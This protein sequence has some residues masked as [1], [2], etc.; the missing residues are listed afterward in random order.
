[1]GRGLWARCLLALAAVAGSVTLIGTIANS[2][3]AA[4]SNRYCTVRFVTVKFVPSTV[5]EGGSTQ[6]QETIRNCTVRVQKVTDTVFGREPCAVIDPAAHSITVPP[7]GRVNE[8]YGFTALSCT[9]TATVTTR[10]TSSIGK[11]FG[12]RTATFTIIA[13]P[14]G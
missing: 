3:E 4:P 11:V 7:R 9:G 6:L 2:A 14:P 10:L 5:P 1:M 12:Q 8:S 13:P